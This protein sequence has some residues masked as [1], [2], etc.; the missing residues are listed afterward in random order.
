MVNDSHTW[1]KVKPGVRK[2]PSS[3]QQLVPT[4]SNVPRRVL[5]LYVLLFFAAI[6]NGNDKE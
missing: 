3:F 5:V 1:T 2:A 4:Y 6:D